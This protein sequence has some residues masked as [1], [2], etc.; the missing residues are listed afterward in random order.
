[1]GLVTNVD[2]TIKSTT[3][4]RIGCRVKCCEMFCVW[5]MTDVCF[6]P[7]S[8]GAWIVLGLFLDNFKEWPNDLTAY[9]F[10]QSVHNWTSH[11]SL[12]LVMVE[13]A[14]CLKGYQLCRKLD[15][16]QQFEKWSAFLYLS[17]AEQFNE[18]QSLHL[19]WSCSRLTP[20]RWPFVARWSWRILTVQRCS[21]RNLT[22]K[23][24]SWRH[25]W[26]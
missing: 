18:M 5:F 9:C 6:C 1:M 10:C 26:S 11:T 3:W 16:D 22:R 12:A 21:V 7:I 25:F 19:N 20:A 15:F 17:I 2:V 13:Q 8:G 23:K 14:N 24:K 4:I